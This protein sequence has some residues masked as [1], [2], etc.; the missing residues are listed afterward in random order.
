MPFVIDGVTVQNI[1]MDGVNVKKVLM[2]GVTVFENAPSINLYAAYS[3]SNLDCRVEP[4]SGSTNPVDIPAGNKFFCVSKTSTNGFRPVIYNGGQ[5]WVTSSYVQTTP[6]S[7]A[8]PFTVKTTDWVAISKGAHKDV[9][10]TATGSA[11]ISTKVTANYPMIILDEGVSTNGRYHV[12]F[13]N[14][15]DTWYEGWI[16]TSYIQCVTDLS[17]I[18]LSA[19]EF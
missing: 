8:T 12:R 6:A 17:N 15:G 4:V 9:Y 5:Y 14:L 1:I 18:D 16:T 19:W 7:F 2:D 11:T 3:G 13:N 10:T